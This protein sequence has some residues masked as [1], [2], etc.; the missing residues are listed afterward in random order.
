MLGEH[1]FK[2]AAGVGLKDLIAVEAADVHDLVGQGFRHDVYFAV[3]S[4]DKRIRLVRVQRDG[5]VAG[6]RPDGRRPDDEVEPG[7]VDMR[8]LAEIVAHGELHI[9]GGAGVVLI[10]D[11]S[12]GKGGLILGAPVNGL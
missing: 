7:V 1:V 5:K 11:L 12:L 8:E 6:Q 9:H 4:L 3:G 2:E 10:L